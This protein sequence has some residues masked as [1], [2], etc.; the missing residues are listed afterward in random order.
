MRAQS[1]M[2][3]RDPLD[4]S[5]NARKQGGLLFGQALAGGAARFPLLV[6]ASADVRLPLHVKPLL[7][8]G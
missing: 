1:R 8:R 7:N 4:Q 3:L 2:E 5:T 6:M